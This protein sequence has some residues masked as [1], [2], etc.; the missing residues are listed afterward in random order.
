MERDESHIQDQKQ[1]RW[2]KCEA[3]EHD[4]NGA[5]SKALQEGKEGSIRRHRRARAV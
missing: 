3:G 1:K 2:D 5:R 4:R